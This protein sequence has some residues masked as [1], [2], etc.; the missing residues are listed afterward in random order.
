[1]LQIGKHIVSSFSRELSLCSRLC[2]LAAP[3]L[4][5]RSYMHPFHSRCSRCCTR[6]QGFR[7][8]SEQPAYLIFFASDNASRFATVFT[9]DKFNRC[10]GWTGGSTMC[11]ATGQI[12]RPPDQLATGSC[13]RQAAAEI[14]A[15][16]C[17]YRA[18]RQMPTL[19]QERT[20]CLGAGREMNCCPCTS[21]WQSKVTCAFESKDL[22]LQAWN[23]PR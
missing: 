20:C 7:R 6:T 1:M 12:A 22:F 23:V 8:L 10:A 11:V 9:I 5:V 3:S 19:S 21:T 13:G 18:A 14:P 17:A 4:C 16:K 15:V 2:T